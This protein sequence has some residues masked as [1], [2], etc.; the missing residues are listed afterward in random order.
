MVGEERLAGGVD[1]V[2][3]LE[4]GD[5]GLAGALGADQAL[6][7]AQQLA[8][9]RLGVH[10]RRRALGVG[11]REEVEDQRQVLAEALVEQQQLAGDPLARR[12]VGVL[13]GD[14]EVGAH[15]LRAPAAAGPTCAC[16]WPEVW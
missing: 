7:H 16:A 13:L 15:D 3:V 9:A 1:P 11:H 12:L 8:L 5:A 14:V 6:G 10:A 4:Q 2:Q